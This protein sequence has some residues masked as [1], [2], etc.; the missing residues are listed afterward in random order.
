VAHTF[1]L[2]RGAGLL[3][4]LSSARGPAGDVGSYA[5][6]G[7][8]ARWLKT[9]G[10]NLWQLLPLNEVSPG[11]DSPYAASSSCALEPVY[12][13]LASVEDV[14]QLDDGERRAFDQV[15]AQDRVDFNA[16]RDAKRSALHRAFERFRDAGGMQ[17]HALRAF[18]EEHRGW[19]EDWAIYRALHDERQKSWRDWEPELRDRREDALRAARDR[20]RDRIDELIYVQW[21]ADAQWRKGRAEA[22]ALGVKV[23]GDLPF[24]VAEDSA[25]VWSFQH[26]FRFDATVGV[27]PDAYSADGQDWGLP[28]QRWDEM[29]EQGDPWLHQRAKRASELYDAFRVDHVVGLYRTYARPIDKSAPYFVPALEAEQRAQGER[30]LTLLGEKAEVLA[31]DLGTVPDFVRASLAEL[32]IPGTKVLRWEN[33]RGVPRDVTKF[34]HVSVAV[35]G[36][37]DTESLRTWWEAL[38]EWEREQQLTQPQLASLRG[39]EQM[40]YTPQTRAA[41][42]ELAYASNSDALL[43]PITDAFGWSDRMNTPG[44]VG[45]HNWTFRLPWSTQELFSAPEP[46][47]TAR[48]LAHLAERYGRRR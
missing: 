24:M 43:T 12:V 25:D 13:D 36:T 18:R 26:L 28:V 6:A 23:L 35:T 20:L 47:A 14:K 1:A 39:P 29:R 17:Q 11:Q 3:I 16:V 31:E 4:P 34:S 21:I 8:I 30:I 40:R 42:L 27:P 15:R 9:A 19:I 44:T 2:G 41:L 48:E 45:T 7:L 37:H 10:C 33:D 22:N 46:V 32:E 5:D 38:P